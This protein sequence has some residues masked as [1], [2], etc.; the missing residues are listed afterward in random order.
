[1][2]LSLRLG[3]SFLNEA[4][5]GWVPRL[6]LGLGASKTSGIARDSR[7]DDLKKQIE[8][9]N[10]QPPFMIDNG[11]ILRAAPKK[12]MSHRRHRTK[13]YTPGDKQ[14][15]PLNNIVRCPA[16]GH[17]KRS[18]F[19]CMH[20]FAEIRTFLKGKKRENGLI[21]DVENPQSDLDP[22]DERI[23]Y[24]GKFVQEDERMLQKKE[25]IPVREEPLM[26]N[27]KQ[28]KHIKR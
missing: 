20:C 11:T 19:M 10:G 22:V 12:K 7:L 2:S 15:H 25:W 1:M 4:L 6:T 14:M 13:L 18:H 9:N 26:Y 21:K 3:G 17:V 23:L 24:P 27:S 28:T 16:C 5:L 8:A